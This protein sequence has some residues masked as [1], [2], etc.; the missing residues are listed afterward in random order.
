MRIQY[1]RE[2]IAIK[3]QG[4]YSRAA[5]SLYV[6]QPVLSRHIADMEKELGV[7]LLNRNKHTVELTEVGMKV[8]LR[9]QRIVQ[10]Y[11]VLL[12]DVANF[13]T[14]ITGTLRLGMLYYT[15]KQDFSSVLSKFSNQYPN[16]EFIRFYYQPHEVFQALSEDRID[17]GV[18][19]FS[20]FTSSDDL[21]FQ[22]FYQDGMEVM[23]AVRHPLAAKENLTLDDLAREECIFLRDDPITNQCYKE[24]LERCGFT[25]QKTLMVGDLDAVPHVLQTTHAIYIKAKGFSFPGYDREIVAK[26][27]EAKNLYASKA[28]A[29][30]TDN[31]NPLIPL[32]LELVK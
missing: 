1:M 17:I 14:G 8:Y 10:N 24:A 15:I 26:S 6:T 19:P 30:R 27:I 23:M 22:N 16:V 29:Y 12:Q 5:K 28:Y 31:L 3:E 4:N 20:T 25:A 21:R 2:L 13:K 32:F 7:K 18:L 9:F 11:D